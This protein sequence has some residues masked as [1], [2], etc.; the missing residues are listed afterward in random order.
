MKIARLVLASALAALGSLSAFAQSPKSYGFPVI[1]TFGVDQIGS[2]PGAYTG[3]QGSDGVLYFGGRGL[4]T[5]DGERWSASAIRGSS[6]VG[7]FS[8]SDDGRIWAAADAEAGAFERKPDGRWQFKSLRDLVP[9]DAE[10]H[11]SVEGILSTP[12]RVDF[13][14]DERAYQWDG[15]E[16]RSWP[17]F[18]GRGPWTFVVNGE[19]WAQG[20][21]SPMYVL[22]KE[23]PKIVEQVTRTF[24]GA[25]KAMVLWVAQNGREWLW[26]TKE[27]LF[28][29]TPTAT[30]PLPQSTTELLKKAAVDSVLRLP[31]GRF[32]FC[33]ANAGLVLTQSDGTVDQVLGEPDG[34]SRF[35]RRCFVDRDGMLWALSSTGT[36]RINI[37]PNTR[38]FDERAGVAN[39]PYTSIAISDGSVFASNP[40]GVM[41]LDANSRHF[42]E[43]PKLGTLVTNV[44]SS[45]YGLLISGMRGVRVRKNEASESLVLLPRNARL[46]LPSRVHPEEILL[47]C[48]DRTVSSVVQGATPVALL[49]GLPVSGDSLAEDTEHNLWIGTA[50]QGLFYG[51]RDPSAPT[52]AKRPEARFGLPELTG[53]VLVQSTGEG[54]VIVASSQGGWVKIH[55]QQRFAPIRDFPAREVAAI[56]SC[57]SDGSIWIAHTR[58]GPYGATMARLSSEGGWHWTPHSI[59]DLDVI[60]PPRSIAAEINS[61]HETVLWLG[62][63]SAI[64]RHVVVHGPQAPTPR[65]PI[66]HAY[67]RDRDGKRQPLA[68]TIAYSTP[69]VEFEFAEP[70]TARRPQLTLQTKITGIDTDWVSANKDSIRDLTALR[71]GSYTFAVRA[72]A[73]TGVVSEPTVFSFVV[74][75]PWWRTPMAFWLEAAALL[76][77]IT[78]G[79][80]WRVRSLRHRNEQLEQKVQERTEELAEASAAKTQFVANMSHDIRNPLNGIVGL[81]LALEDTPLDGQQRE[82]VATLRECTTYL[83]SLVDDVL[84][85][86]SIEAGRIELRTAP[87]VPSELLNSVVTTLKAECSTR[88]AFITIET[89]PEIAP[90]LQGDAGRIQ[91]I[92]VNY[93]SNALKYAGGHIRLSATVS[94]TAPGEVEYAVTDEG[95]GISAADQATLFTKFSRLQ[96]ARRSHIPGTGLG[97]AACRLLADFMGGSVGVESELGHGARFYLRLP[98]VVA[99]EPLVATDDLKL[100]PTSVLLVED[101]DYNALAA[102]AVLG[103]LGLVCDRASTGAEAI[104]LFNEKRHHI[105]LLDRNLPDMDG[106]EVARRLREIETDGMHSVL[107][108]VT[109]YCTSDDRKLCLDAGMDAFVGKPLTPDKLRKVLLSAANQMLGTG[110]IAAPLA[111]VV[112]AAPAGEP[113]KVVD[114][115]LL[116]YLA[117]GTEGGVGAQI[118]RFVGELNAAHAHLLDT[119]QTTNLTALAD[120]AHRVLGHAR[121]V[122]AP[123]LTELLIQLETAA[124]RMDQAGVDRALPALAPQIAEL[125]AALRRHPAAQRA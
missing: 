6:T 9:H 48:Y 15:H 116:E 5:F 46:A 22:S 99:S 96:G 119:Q 30:K 17:L 54:D 105:V 123:R 51:P 55:G 57:L 58:S 125:T 92:L 97:L 56:S 59:P 87:Y 12:N 29:S 47:S 38:V 10:V 41:I 90:M 84:D 32:V 13:V 102:K 124:R 76:L 63:S 7:T 27:N 101:T 82:L 52:S 73:E 36:Q 16:V 77:L 50:S 121:M 8:V 103:K 49:N 86:A 44:S 107:L 11:G 117:D 120:A 2:D 34:V 19:L 33:T 64:M 65:A 25:E 78:G 21:G 80:Q 114:L 118:E 28:L 39:R 72:V 40:Q 85:F 71:D 75:P 62:G 43:L 95:Q 53:M 122:G 111:V 110:S 94:P 104:A 93:V 60:G 81:T 106:T 70:D 18:L 108:A 115:T 66:L 83:S 88:G 23:G 37:D 24:P 45:K 20:Y 1:R 67:A 100:P 4:L 14:S 74:A 31:D 35:V 91:Q 3:I 79:V 42:S 113:A 61:A 69:G 98:L 89:D 109:A 26:G 112:P 68:G